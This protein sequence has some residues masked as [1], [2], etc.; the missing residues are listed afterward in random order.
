MLSL[1]TVYYKYLQHFAR[2]ITS[3]LQFLLHK[4]ISVSL[5]LGLKLDYHVL[6][7]MKVDANW[8]LSDGIMY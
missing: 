4:Q 7:I 2:F 3:K 1:L 6:L 8:G 5:A